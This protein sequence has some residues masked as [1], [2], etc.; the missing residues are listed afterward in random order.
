MAVWVQ[1][2]L[3]P[4]ATCIASSPKVSDNMQAKHLK[5]GHRAPRFLAVADGGGTGTRLRLYSIEGTLLGQSEAGPSAL[6]LGPAK[7]WL[8][9]TAA[10]DAAAAAAGLSAPQ[11]SDVA[12]GI[13]LSGAE[14]V[15]LSEGF[16]AVQPGLS[17]LALDNDGVCTVLG[18]HGGSPGV[19]VAAGTGTV[20][21]ALRPDGSRQLA[22]GWGWRWGDE[23]GGAWLGLRAISHAQQAVDGRARTGALA[24]AILTRCGASRPALSGWC[25]A[26]GQTEF[27]SLAPLVFDASRAGDPVARRLLFDAVRALAQVA[28]AL[29]PR[30]RL[31]LTFAGS[32]GKRLA[33]RMPTGLARRCVE[34]QGDAMDGAMHLLRHALN[35]PHLAR[36]P[37]LDA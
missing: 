1:S 32:I 24:H 25:Q 30:G 36:Q 26:A 2:T 21:V 4:R 7:A 35:L 13:G 10:L 29:D 33:S 6:G 14:S 16:L 3:A 8:P 22:S 20:G 18:A 15:P 31:P 19:V 23:G 11:W 5:R 27:A 17:L 28:R 9:L 12:L 37:Q 34:A